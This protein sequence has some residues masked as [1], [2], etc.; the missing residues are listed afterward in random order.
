VLRAPDGIRDP[1]GC[2]AVT[3]LK[4]YAETQDSD[5]KPR[6]PRLRRALESI[7]L[8]GPV[9]AVLS[10][11]LVNWGNQGLGALSRGGY[12]AGTGDHY[13]LGPEGLR[14]ADPSRFVGDFFLDAAPE[15]HWF[16]DLVTA[17][18]ASTGDVSA[19][20]LVYWFVGLGFFGFGAALLAKAWAPRFAWV[21]GSAFV[22]GMFIAPWSVVGTGSPMIASPIPA[23]VGGYAAFFFCAVI[24]TGRH[25]LSAVMAVVVAVLHVQ[26][27]LVVT[28][29]IAVTGVALSIRDRRPN[30]ALLAGAVGGGAV[31]AYGL[32]R[33]SFGGAI[34][35]FVQVCDEMIP[36]HCSAHLWGAPAVLSAVA[37]ITLSAFSVRL[38]PREQRLTWYTSVGLM[39]FGLLS[40]MLADVLR[41][42]ALGALAQGS[43]IYRLGAVVV[44][45]AVWGLFSYFLSPVRSRTDLV[46]F[47]AW[48]LVAW[49]VLSSGGWQ[50]AGAYSWKLY[51]LLVPLAILGAAAGWL[52]R[53]REVV[54]R[55]GEGRTSLA[56]GVATA[57][58]IA[59]L[60]AS[61]I[62]GSFITP[63]G[64]DPQY[65]PNDAIREWGQQVERVVPSGEIIL[66]SPNAPYIRLASARGNLGD[67]K[68]V[69]YGGD[70]YREWQE[71]MD[72]LGGWRAQ[73]LWP[74]PAEPFNALTSDELDAIAQK[75]DVDYLVLE[76]PQHDALPGLL[77]GDWT[78][79]LEPFNELENIVLKRD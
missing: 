37:L 72:D 43:N 48:L 73:C 77:A 34:G 45:F 40:G 3:A 50:V 26:Q 56:S 51:A 11:V 9:F 22:F 7:W 25:V 39:G 12:T 32:S 74:F 67:C 38:V 52:S 20:Y 61:S 75:Y 46:F 8:M 44:F 79:V 47:A 29:V 78:V 35:E 6:P 17:L 68:S 36:Y 69:P 14:M 55:I 63:R 58:V 41:I 42:P 57:A 49:Y 60:V 70:P 19:T 65:I 28:I 1:V 16:F 54:D 66:H 18:G 5:A 15:P 10:G 33:N 24:L 76:G 64:L 2:C 62:A 59:V 53:R 4:G 27:G 21:A 71:R 30:W 31:V 13:V 23:V